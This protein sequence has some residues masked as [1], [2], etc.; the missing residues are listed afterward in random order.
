MSPAAQSPVVIPEII[1]MIIARIPFRSRGRARLVNRTWN[2]MTT[3]TPDEYNTILDRAV[4][5]GKLAAVDRLL[6]DDR[7]NGYALQKAVRL[8][9]YEGHL[10]ILD[11]LLQDPR[12]DPTT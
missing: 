5:R 10:A 3:F 1:R 2:E 12:A 8:A 11:R 9:A 6:Q 7:V 4:Y